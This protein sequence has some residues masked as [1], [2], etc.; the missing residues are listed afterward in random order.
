MVDYL[1]KN[2]Q[3][4]PPSHK[5]T[6]SQGWMNSIQLFWWGGLK[7]F[8]DVFLLFPDNLAWKI[9]VATYLNRI[10]TQPFIQRCFMSRL[11]VISPV[12]LEKKNYFLKFEYVYL[13]FRY[14]LALEKDGALNWHNLIHPSFW[15]ILASWFRNYLFVFCQCIF[16]IISP[17]PPLWK[18]F[19]PSSEQTLITIRK[20]AF[21]LVRLKIFK[22]F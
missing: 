17:N 12:V 8:V 1:W 18:R 20:D 19:G 22:I 13:P 2:T 3:L 10:E 4:N 11:A 21:C 16:V 9:G 6:L 14:Y 7:N 5:D 15:L